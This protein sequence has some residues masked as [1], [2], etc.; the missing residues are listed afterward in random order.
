MPLFSDQQHPIQDPAVSAALDQDV[1]A[2]LQ[3]MTGGVWGLGVW[4][5][6]SAGLLQWAAS[7]ELA[8]ITY[9]KALGTVSLTRIGDHTMLVSVDCVNGLTIGGANTPYIL[10]R[11]PD[12]VQYACRQP[13]DAVL[14]FRGP[15]ASTTLYNPTAGTIESGYVLAGGGAVGGPSSMVF[16]RNAG[17]FLNGNVYHIWAQWA[18]EVAV[19]GS[20]S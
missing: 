10:M 5:R 14:N 13:I 12:G 16:A 19:V 9:G 1:L 2:P 6:Y 18:M 11:L 4:R 15:I 8:S 7:S 3:G 20:R 17:N